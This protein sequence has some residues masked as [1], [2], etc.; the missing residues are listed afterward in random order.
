MDII[1]EFGIEKRPVSDYYR[2]I[3][4]E[5]KHR[6]IGHF[7]IQFM[8]MLNVISAN[9]N[10]FHPTIFLI[11]AVTDI[12]TMKRIRVVAEHD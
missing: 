4:F 2:R 1:G 12:L 6:F 7:I 3:G 5:K 11:F 8:N 10:Y 9:A